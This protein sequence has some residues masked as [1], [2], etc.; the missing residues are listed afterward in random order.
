MLQHN[1]TLALRNLW[2]YKLQTTISI[3]SIAIGIVVLA[4]VHSMLSL[5]FRLPAITT[6]PHYEHSC[7]LTLDSLHR[8]DMANHRENM[9]EASSRIYPDVEILRAIRNGGELRGVELGPTFPNRMWNQPVCHFA[10]GDTLERQITAQLALIDPIYPNYAGYVSA[11]TGKPIARLRSGEAI[12]CATLARE[13]FGDANPIGA[14]L[15]GKYVRE[16]DLTVVDVYRDLGQL[17][18]PPAIAAILFSCNNEEIMSAPHTGTHAVP[19]MDFVLKPDYTP[20]QLE[21]EINRRL[22]PLG[23]KSEAQWVKDV[24]AEDVA[25][26]NTIR[27]VIYFLGSLILLASI[28]GYLRMQMQFFWMRKREVSLRMVHGAK[29]WQIFV[30]LMTE[31][32]VVL[33]LALGLSMLLGT[34]LEEFV[35]VVYHSLNGA[36]HIQVLGNQIPACAAVGGI[37]LLICSVMVWLT[38]GRIV[39]SEQGL[40]E[41][42]RVSR[43][44]GF[45][46]TMLWLQITVSMFFVS[47]ALLMANFCDKVANQQ[48]L[49]DDFT[50]Y[51]NSIVVD[52]YKAG[53]R[54][55]LLEELGKMPELERMFPYSETYCLF[56]EIAEKDSLWRSRW[57]S[58]YMECLEVSD[59]TSLD[60]FRV[61]GVSWM[62][63]ELKGNERSVLI[64][65]DMYAL[66]VSEGILT[67]GIL[68][69]TTMEG[70]VPYPVVGTFEDIVFNEKR[71]DMRTDFIVINPIDDWV[72]WNTFLLLPKAGDDEAL[73]QAVNAVIERMEPTKLDRFA[74]SF[75]EKHAPQVILTDNM[76]KAGWTLGAVALLICVMGIYSTIALDTRARRKEMAIRKIN[77]AKSKDIAMLF[78]RLYFM[79]I[80]FAL[81]VILPIVIFVQYNLHAM[82]GNDGRVL[83]LI[84]IVLLCLT[85]C[86]MVIL[87]IVLIVGRHVHG[88]MRVNP[89]EIIAKE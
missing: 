13:I 21:E 68:M 78:S 11:I 12:M 71:E 58:A 31:V 17:D 69:Q 63:H 50:P 36:E 23:L 86:F 82:E 85:G 1:L 76:R 15:K 51:E 5:H 40:A 42:M 32:V 74:S 24:L 57:G 77:G 28:V 7:R 53:N 83:R 18:A 62:R 59:T 80:A 38:L 81:A 87:S 39:R 29:R 72:T 55:L 37:L 20:E 67:N 61:S 47:A 10:L 19:W 41:G 64:N 88:I 43:S 79:L 9:A 89:A 70:Y 45:R 35:N 52:V 73:R 2:K 60:F 22:E 4:A 3:V 48:V 27:T 33:L 49:P 8:E 84:P 16:Q 14:S 34:W 65:K 6:T 26:I 30:L 75:M 25:R 66:L 54:L 46:N 44:H 56:K